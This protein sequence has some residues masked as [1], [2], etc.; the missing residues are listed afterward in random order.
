MSSSFQPTS[1]PILRV[2]CPHPAAP[3][4]ARAPPID[5]DHTKSGPRGRRSRVAIQWWTGGARGAGSGASAAAE[6]VVRSFGFRD[7]ATA[8]NGGG[9]WGRET[10]ATGGG[11]ASGA[12]K[13][14]AAPRGRFRCGCDAAAGW[15][16]SLSLGASFFAFDGPRPAAPTAPGTD[17]LRRRGGSHQP[18]EGVPTLSWG[19]R[20]AWPRRLGLGPAGSELFGGA[21]RME[22]EGWSE[23]WILVP[24]CPRRALFW[25]RNRS[26]EPHTPTH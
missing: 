4:R 17:G 12:W 14:R 10:A 23:G 24:A 19:L 2:L 1:I 18:R 13:R 5:P 11:R 16:P 26:I 3:S 9:V 8:G 20:W 7:A 21:W 25:N 15:W 6:N 22:S